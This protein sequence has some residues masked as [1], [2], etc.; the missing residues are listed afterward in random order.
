MTR[1]NIIFALASILVLVSCQKKEQHIEMRNG[2]QIV[3]D[4]PKPALPGKVEEKRIPPVDG[5]Y[6]AMTFTETEHDFGDIKQGD[7]VTYFFE[8]KNTGQAD[9]L[10]SDAHGS[11][12][13][14]VPEYP[15]EAIKPGQ[16]E[17][18]KVSFDSKG[19]MGEQHKTVTLMTNTEA[20]AE[21]LAIQANINK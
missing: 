1:R 16:S 17:K 4:G 20:G 6:P 13:C 10:I 7:K 5:K 9:L 15:K 19:K 11:C 14:T 2:R 3:V 8:F 12:G 18:I 21:K